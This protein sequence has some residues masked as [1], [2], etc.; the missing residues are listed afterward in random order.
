MYNMGGR[1]A[2]DRVFRNGSALKARI[3]FQ[4]TW[5]ADCSGRM[6]RVTSDLQG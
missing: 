3:Q 6:T 2:L 5:D 4:N 1:F